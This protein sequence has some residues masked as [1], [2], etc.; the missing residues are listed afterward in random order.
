MLPQPYFY[1]DSVTSGIGDWDSIDAQQRTAEIVNVEVNKA[2]L[3]RVSYG[4]ESTYSGR[5]GC[6]R[7]SHVK[8]ANYRIEDIYIHL[9]E[10]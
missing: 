2:I 4:I 7:V 1:Q 10:I 8:Q 5:L 9:R 3:N 6:K